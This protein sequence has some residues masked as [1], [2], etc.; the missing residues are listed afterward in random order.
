MVRTAG[1]AVGPMPEEIEWI[2]AMSNYGAGVSKGV[3]R[4]RSHGDAH[5]DWER[6]HAELVVQIARASNR[7]PAPS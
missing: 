1:R 2:G 6:W 4:Y 3:L 5:A 7:E